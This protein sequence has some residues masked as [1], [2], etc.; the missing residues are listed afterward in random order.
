MS[1]SKTLG[2]M[3][4]YGPNSFVQCAW[5]DG[6]FAVEDFKPNKLIENVKEWMEILYESGVDYVVLIT[7]HHDGFCLWN[8][9]Y[10]DYKSTT[11]D[12]NF[13]LV[14]IV[15][16]ECEKYGI[17]LGLYYSL[18]DLNYQ[19]YT[20]D[21]EYNKFVRNQITELLTNY[22]QVG[23]LW[24]DGAWDK[25]HP[26]GEASFNPK[27]IT[28]NNPEYLH[29]ERWEWKRL[30]E[31][32]HDIAPQCEVI[33]N[34]GCSRPG[35]IKYMPIDVRVSERVNFVVD[36]KIRKAQA[37]HSLLFNGKEYS[38]GLE[39][40]VSLN[41]DWFYTG[42]TRYVQTENSSLNYLL[43]KAKEEENRLLINIGP[44]KNCKLIDCEKEALYS[45][46]KE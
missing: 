16:D 26:N 37:E 36:G 46:V 22:K 33:N 35:I 41:P 13:D 11:V 15:S 4:S 17:E 18:W 24:F 23:E 38:L 25:D 1:K 34:S 8:T 44:D 5:G 27:W 45:L 6:K 40:V 21:I 14:Q 2:V 39:Y 43:K 20:D 32:I 31:H 9:E 28:E 10:T 7:K 30:Y 12:S 42:G 29:G 3:I 19:H